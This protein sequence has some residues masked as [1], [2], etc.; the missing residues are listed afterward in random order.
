MES[1]AMTAEQQG[2]RLQQVRICSN[3]T[4]VG[5]EIK[6]GSC[7]PPEYL[8]YTGIS[9]KIPLPPLPTLKW[10]LGSQDPPIPVSQVHCTW[11]P[12]GWSCPC[13]RCSITVS[14][15]DLACPLQ[16]YSRLHNEADVT[17]CFHYALESQ[18]TKGNK[19]ESW[20]LTTPERFSRGH[21]LAK[22]KVFLNNKKDKSNFH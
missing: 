10:G 19:W 12:L 4:A 5:I 16:W 14:S 1:A 15:L 18:S 20:Q 13:T 3:A 22:W 11:A 8:I 6:E 7:L 21:K 9:S 2:P 17:S